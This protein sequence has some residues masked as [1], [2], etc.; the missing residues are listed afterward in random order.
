MRRQES[1]KRKIA[2]KP[3]DAEKM[4]CQSQ[5]LQRWKPQPM[6]RSHIKKRKL[7]ATTGKQRNGKECPQ[8]TEAETRK[9]KQMMQLR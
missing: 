6:R 4:I 1:W 8:Q 5:N 3:T 2:R 9:N 7:E